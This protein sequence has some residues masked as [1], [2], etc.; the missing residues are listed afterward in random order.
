M[1]HEEHPPEPSGCELLSHPQV[2]LPLVLLQGVQCAY[3]V[4]LPVDWVQDDDVPIQSLYLVPLFRSV[5]HPAKVLPGL[6]GVHNVTLVVAGPYVVDEHPEPPLVSY[7]MVHALPW[8][9]QVPL[10]LFQE[11]PLSHLG[12]LV[13]PSHVA[14][15][16]HDGHAP[17]FSQE[18]ALQ[19]VAV[20]S[21][22]PPLYLL[23]V[24]ADEFVTSDV[25]HAV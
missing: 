6:D 18:L 14:C 3:I 10:A 16:G 4:M 8:A 15:A 17:F 22:A 23:P 9:S 12:R 5:Y 19:D 7:V 1:L 2:P 24:T 25:V 11:Y 21:L 20:Q 13:P